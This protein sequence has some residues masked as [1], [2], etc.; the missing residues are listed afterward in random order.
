V[1]EIFSGGLALAAHLN[2]ELPY[3]KHLPI[4]NE[5]VSYKIPSH[6]RL[7]LVGIKIWRVF[8]EADPLSGWWRPLPWR[9]DVRMAAMMTKSVALHLNWALESKPT[10]FRLLG[11]DHGFLAEPPNF[12][13]QRTLLGR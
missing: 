2:K 12:F 8:S 4:S 3:L 10:H 9:E 5:L 6:F 13:S 7:N 11:G 1:E